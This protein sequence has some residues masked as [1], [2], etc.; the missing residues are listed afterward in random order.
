MKKLIIIAFIF[1]Q[2]ASYSQEK[3]FT[4]TGKISFY[5]HAIVEDIEAENN[6]VFCIMDFKKKEISI[7][8]LIR[9]F[10]FE[11]ALMEE[12]FNENYLESEKYSYASFYG[13]FTELEKINEVKSKFRFS[14]KIKIH[15]VEKEISE[16]AILVKEVG[17]YNLSG[18][19]KLKVADFDIEIPSVVN[20]NIAK[21][22]EVKV[23]LL[24]KPYEK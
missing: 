12:H 15:G 22:I 19:F 14:G 23:D 4:K 11:K 6:Q 8:L 9:S 13:A 21:E 1:L 20:D 18:S 10:H 24:L 2:L 16:E 7:K 5:S 17:K 3:Y